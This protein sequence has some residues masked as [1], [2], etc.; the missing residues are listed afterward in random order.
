[1]DWL[2]ATTE[3]ASSPARIAELVVVG[4]NALWERARPS[5]GDTTLAVLFDRALLRPRHARA[6]HAL[7]LHVSRRSSVAIDDA[8]EVS[9]EL[10][11]EAPAIVVSV[12]EILSRATAGALTPALHATLMAIDETPD[13]ETRAA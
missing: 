11:E 13:S 10:A 7:G 4:L 9:A 1:M 2:F 12:L 5:L 6:V 3:K 8:C